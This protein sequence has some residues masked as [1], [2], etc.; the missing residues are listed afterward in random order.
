MAR[1]VKQVVFDNS[2]TPT[3]KRVAA[4]ARV[5]SAKDAMLH[6]LSAQ[7]SHYSSLIQKNPGWL[8]CGVYADEAITGTK[9]NR[10]NFQKLLTEC[11]A[12]KID[13]V[14]TKSISRFA[15]NTV[16]L[17]S[18]VRELK[19]LGVDVYFEE[20][21][22]HSLSENGELMLTL[23]ASFAQEE[24][25]SASEN[26]KW[27][28]KKN[29]EEGKPWNYTVYGYRN[30]HGT[31]EVYEKE[32]EIVRF[33]FSKYLEGMGLSAIRDW[34]N[35]NKIPTR[36]G[37]KWTHR[38]IA[39]ILKNEMYTGRL[40]LQKTYRENH[41]TK[42]RL[43][44]SGQLPKYRAEETHQP[45]IDM[46]TFNTVQ[47]EM[48]RRKEKFNCGEKSCERYSFTGTIKC[49]GCGASYRRK[50]RG[51]KVH[52]ICSTYNSTGKKNCPTSSAIPEAVLKDVISKVLGIVSFDDVIFRKE[53]KGIYACKNRLLRIE[54]TDGSIIECVW[55]MPSRSESW[56]PEKRELARQRKLEEINNARCNSNTCNN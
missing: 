25:L 7:V 34:L 38:T 48:E 15:R 18:T 20:Q 10:A 42:K 8:Y 41:I 54:K 55:T 24:S 43:E 26:Q 50:I 6:S 33:I 53:I 47:E 19:E 9:E 17:L 1:I 52:W 14:I 40:L 22:I 21:N 51:E 2:K 11:K 28:I 29:F 32:A 35:D 4:Y 31:L 39:I 45:I 5:S 56:T 37:S 49:E 12:G 13:M 46:E 23:L 16:T 36:F 3:V 27:R 30:N 44:N